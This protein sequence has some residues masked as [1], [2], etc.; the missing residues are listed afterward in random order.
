MSAF[1]GRR[2]RSPPKPMLDVIVAGA[3][4]AGS[5]AALLLARAGVRVLIV[6]RDTF[7]RDK[8]CGDTV[9][10][11][12]IRVLASLGLSGGPLS[13]GRPLRGMR[14]SGPGASVTAEYGPHAGCAVRRTELDVWL[15]EHAMAA[16]ARFESGVVVRGPLVTSAEGSQ[17]R[18]IVLTARGATDRVTRMPAALVIA[19]DGSRSSLARSLQLVAD[20]VRTRRWAFGVYAG[21]VEG[22]GDFGEMHVRRGAYLGIAPLADG[23]A[24]VCMVTGPRPDGRRPLEVIE[25]LIASE[26]A[27][28]ARFR[29]A[30]FVGRPR[31]LGPLAVNATAAGVDG[32]LLAGDAAGF[33]DPMTGD[34]LHLAIRGAMLAADEALRAFQT[35]DFAGAAARLAAARQRVLGAK[36]RF[37]RAVRAATSSPTAIGVLS[38]AAR[39]APAVMRPVI[40]YAG[41]V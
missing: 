23:L 31:V 29:R 7:P 17:V 6:D 9:N 37:N 30:T 32:L 13:T 35:S 40:R 2:G 1:G 26:P 28:A 33:V 19:A 5:I 41:D 4:P 15:L 36:L 22:V 39:I 21:G 16:G 10:P 34:G 24:N 3:G 12:A 38:V 14:L 11:G 18:G 25:R 20:R 8:L 27:L